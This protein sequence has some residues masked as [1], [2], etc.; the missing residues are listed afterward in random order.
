MKKI[1]NQYF[2]KLQID[3]YLVHNQIKYL[4]YSNDLY[5]QPIITF[6]NIEISRQLL[7]YKR[8]NE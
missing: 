6:Q 4:Y 3:F 5:Q 8:K 2:Y 1:Y 7:L